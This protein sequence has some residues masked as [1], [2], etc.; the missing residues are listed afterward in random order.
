MKYISTRNMSII[1]IIK[2]HDTLLGSQKPKPYAMAK[3]WDNLGGA[4]TKHW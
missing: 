4:P 3:H 1:V 2:S